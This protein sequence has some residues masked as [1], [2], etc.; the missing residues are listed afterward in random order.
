VAQWLERRPLAGEL[1]L[2]YA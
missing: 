1:S 2:N